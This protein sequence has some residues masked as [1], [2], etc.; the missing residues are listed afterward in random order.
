MASQALDRIFDRVAGTLTDAEILAKV[1]RDDDDVPEALR[2]PGIAC[3][4]LDQLQV[5]SLLTAPLVSLCS[6]PPP[7]ASV[8]EAQYEAMV[9]KALHAPIGETVRD[10]TKSLQRCSNA[11]KQTGPSSASTR[12]AH[13]LPFSTAFPRPEHK[14]ICNKPPS[15]E[16]A[17]ENKI[18]V[19]ATRALRIPLIP[20]TLLY[21]VFRKLGL[22]RST[23]WPSSPADSVVQLKWDLVPVYSPDAFYAEGAVAPLKLRG[24]AARRQRAADVAAGVVPMRASADDDADTGILLS[25]LQL[26]SIDVVPRRALPSVLRNALA[27]P[28]RHNAMLSPGPHDLLVDLVSVVAPRARCAQPQVHENSYLFMP[29]LRGLLC[30]LRDGCTHAGS[31]FAKA[32]FDVRGLTEEEIMIRTVN[33]VVVLDTS[34][35]WRLRTH[36]RE[37]A[38]G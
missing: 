27:R 34:N 25:M 5:A 2:H 14:R 26:V 11:K 6:P 30:A 37:D 7:L 28:G 9:A 29:A 15:R 12:S 18:L 24:E 10:T 32:R 38:E 33:E 4:M 31:P 8:P 23:P 17:H 13:L 16:A 20:P 22:D 1:T 36:F 21:L 35:A 3:D 19:L